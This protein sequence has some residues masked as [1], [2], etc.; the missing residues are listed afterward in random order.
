QMELSSLI[1]A[2]QD[3]PP[4]GFTPEA[5]SLG[6]RK[7][8]AFT[9][10]FDLL[11]TADE[12][13]QQKV[14]AVSFLLPQRLRQSLLQPKTLFIGTTVSEFCLFPA[15]FALEEL[16]GV[17]QQTM[18]RTGA[19]YLIAKDLAA[20]APF[21]NDAERKAAQAI[22]DTLVKA[23]FVLLEGQAAAY[24]PIDFASEAEFL[25]R[26]SKNRRKNFRRKLK[27]RSEVTLRLFRTGDSFFQDKQ[28][29]DLLYLLYKT[30]Y[31]A[32]EIHFDLLSREFFTAAFQDSR[33]GGVV[34]TYWQK[35]QL[36]GYFLAYE[37]GDCLVD[38]YMGALYPAYRDCN[39]YFVSWFD[40][41][42]YA[43]QTGKKYVVFGWTSPEI[44]AELG[45][46]FTFT[47]HA[48]YPKNKWMRKLLGLVADSF[49]SDR[50]VLEEWQ[51][52]HQEKR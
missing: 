52:K 50:K 12:S 10:R 1:T 38:K 32:S 25:E 27:S 23:G 34:F 3:N 51:K 39:L 21:F 22:C 42:E 45:A 26:F 15:G 43:R 5:I 30:V 44:K 19:S 6:E 35:E 17:L 40:F 31:D 4:E 18:D 20:D 7:L 16:A 33:S 41:L 36:V 9:T 47:K 37:Q 8:P 13:L 48:V 24:V 14:Q 49:E 28:N 29:L 2:F 11:L 46:E